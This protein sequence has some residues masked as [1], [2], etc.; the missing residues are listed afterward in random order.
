MPARYAR[1]HSRATVLAYRAYARAVR[2]FLTIILVI[3]L[4]GAGLRWAGVKIP[5][6]DYKIGDLGGWVGGPQI[7]NQAPGYGVPLH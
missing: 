4:V 1:P 7:Q 5:L 2:T 3:V 6:V